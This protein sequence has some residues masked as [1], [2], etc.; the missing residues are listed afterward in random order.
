[1]IRQHRHTVPAL[2]AAFLLSLV[3]VVPATADNTAQTVP[4]SQDWSNTGLITTNDNWS[5]VPGVIGFLG[6]DITTG[7]GVDP[8]TLLTESTLTNDVDVIPNQTNT[9]ITNGG[10]A[11]FAITDPV[12]ALQGSGTADAPYLLIHL[13]TTGVSNI[14][15]AYNLRD[16]DGTG[17]NAIQPVALQYR[18]GASGNFTNLPDGFVADATS[19]PFEATLVTPVSAALPAGANNQPLV[20][21]RIMTTNAV[22]NDEWVGVDDISVTAAAGDAAPTV[23]ST[24][25]ANGA[26]NVAVDESIDV[27]F[28]EPVDVTGA[29]YDIDCDTSG[30]HGA[31]VSGGPTTFTLDPDTDF[32][33]GE[34]CTVTIVAAQVT[35]QDTDDPPDAM[36]EDHVVSFTTTALVSDS[37]DVKISQVYGGG[38]NSGATYRNDFI[39]LYNRGDEA[40][41][42]NGWSVQYASAAGSTW[43]VTPLTG[44]VPPAKHYLIQEAAGTGGSVDLPD[45]DAIGTIAMSA[46]Q[47][48]VALV[49]TTTPLTGTC[50]TSPDIADFVG[51]GS[52]NCSETAPTPA[53]SNTTAALRNGNGAIDT[54][55]NLADFT[56]GDPNPR[57]SKDSVPKIASSFPS[58]DA[59][60]VPKWAN[61][62]VTFSEPV[63]VADGWYDLTCATTGSHVADVS[64]GPTAWTINPT[65]TFAGGETCSLVIAADKVTDVDEDDPPDAMSADVTIDF[66]VA[67]DLVCGAPATLISAVQGSGTTS[68]MVNSIVEIEGVVVGAFPGT[69]GFQGLHVQEH[70]ADQDG[71]PTTSEGLFVFE[72]NGGATY[73]VGDTVRVRGRVVEFTSSGQ[74]LTELS[75]LNNLDVCSS[76]DTVTPA[77]VTL[78][79]ASPTFAERYESMLVEIDQELTVTETFSLGRFGEVVLSSGGRLL[80]PTNV[81]EPGSAA[82]ALQ[83][84]NNL[85]RIVLDDGDSRQN[86]DP[87][88]YPTG[89]LSA[90]NTL[91]VGYT[92]SNNTFVLEQRFGVYRLQPTADLPEFVASNPRTATPPSVGGGLQVASF[93]VLNYFDTL[94]LGP[95]IC[96]PDEDQECR[97]ADSETELERQRAKIVAALAGLDADVVGLIELENDSGEAVDDLLA[98]LN[99]ATAAGTYAAIDTGTIG[100][101]AIKVA[102]IYTPAAVTPVGAYAILD[103]SVD[104]RFDD[105]L[106]RPALAQS[107]EDAEGARFTVVV[108][109]LKSKGSACDG[110]PDAGDGQGNCNVTRTE[111]ARALVDWLAS[112]PTGSGDR[113]VLVIGDLNAYAKED[114]ID[115]FVEAGYTNLIEAFSGA[116]AYSYVFEGQSG[117]LDHALASPTLTAQ[118]AGAA[119]W[120]INADEPPVLDYNVEFK[121]LNHVETLYAPTPYRSSDHDPV[122][123]GLDL[124]NFGFDGFLQPVSPTGTTEVNAGSTVPMRFTLSDASGL[125]VLFANPVS[126]ESDCATGEVTGDWEATSATVGLTANDPPHYTY[127]WKTSKSWA[128]SC[129]TFELTLD[130]GSYWRAFFH[131]VK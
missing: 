79:F 6:Q 41:S 16:I 90:S 1:M 57:A 125:G 126:A 71:N 109:H 69:T 61:M 120:H 67:P 3:T 117:Y 104:E 32:A 68:P 53:L 106:N 52:A 83:A 89:G 25:P 12:V 94:D 75:N 86:L 8:Q 30:A 107:F 56:V 78:P 114:P 13:D 66:T 24:S 31:T 100:T 92:T 28:S 105:E 85:R 128:N 47:G 124:L 101:D 60:G 26:T 10:V 39:E 72:P 112:D 103:S 59:T 95:D 21:V 97:G 17:D 54:D 43:Q 80:N 65:G 74:T 121:S 9:A 123:V 116:G 108:N 130:D 84:A 98:A 23:S 2:V 50:P 35:D 62:L 111:A 82:I 119:D 7:T 37:T 11:E 81:V 33:F 27:T 45:P 122:L 63:T 110:D 93:N 49:R 76:G 18:V 46:T 44:S 77:E 64:G 34:E 127:D 36:A 58:D 48:K 20:Q 15:V 131:F 88:L 5:G 113:D 87:T 29:W 70:D 99:A 4:F 55:N 102:L 22:G 115:V 129:R 40:V 118:V 42:V 14:S 73:A 91:R 19:G 96:G 51:Y 38:G